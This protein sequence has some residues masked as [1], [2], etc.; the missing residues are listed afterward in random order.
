MRKRRRQERTL[1]EMLEQDDHQWRKLSTLVK[2]VGE[3]GAEGQ[4]RVRVL[5]TSIGARPSQSRTRRELWGLISRV[6]VGR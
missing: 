4:Q 2:A 5:L 3:T 6:G 1:R